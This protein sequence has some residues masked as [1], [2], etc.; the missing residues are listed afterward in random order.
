[1]SKEEQKK[2]L[3]FVQGKAKEKEDAKALEDLK[4]QQKKDT[5][6][7]IA[8]IKAIQ[9]NRKE[10]I[11]EPNRPATPPPAKTTTPTSEGTQGETEPSLSQKTLGGTDN[12]KL[13]IYGGIGVV[14]IGLVSF[15]LLRNPSGN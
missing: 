12:K 9:A 1:M 8:I 11:L 2:L 5:E 10:G 3:E 15:L 13:Y 14:V 7:G 4:A 6:M